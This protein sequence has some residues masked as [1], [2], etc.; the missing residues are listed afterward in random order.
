MRGSNTFATDSTWA[1]AIQTYLSEYSA[2]FV[3]YYLLSDKNDQA[4]TLVEHLD[5]N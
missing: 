5:E 1:K 2:G 3:Q 4:S